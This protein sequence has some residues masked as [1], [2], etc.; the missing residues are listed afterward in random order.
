MSVR[1]ASLAA[2][3]ALAGLGLTAA[4]ATA[5]FPGANGRIVYVEAGRFHDLGQIATV[6][7]DGTGAQILTQGRQN[8]YPQFFADGKRIAY[9]HA[10]GRS[11]VRISV[12]QSDG[13]NKQ[14]LT[15][16]HV[17]EFPAPSPDGRRIAFFRY[18]KSGRKHLC[19]MR[20]DGTHLHVIERV[21][22]LPA[23]FTWSPSGD[24]IAYDAGF[25]EVLDVVLVTPSGARRGEIADAEDPSFTP[26]GDRLAL[27]YESYLGTT[28]LH[29]RKPVSLT[30][31]LMPDLGF[32]A[33]PKFSPDGTQVAFA[34]GG[35]RGPSDIYVM[36]PGA[37]SAVNVTNTG[38]AYAPDWGP[39]G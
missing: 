10:H 26:D 25:S 1:T 32:Y 16:G 5:T 12:M 7:P 31:N 39:A 34:A 20:S 21:A 13:T 38:K 8:E 3:M 30:G 15:R 6:E 24:L 11:Q 27:S 14:D 2:S 28:D 18:T 19:V 36:A 33:H 9:M 23:N 22:G 4:P 17:D 29:G 35:F 37:S